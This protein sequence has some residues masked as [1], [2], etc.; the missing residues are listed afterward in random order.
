MNKTLKVACVGEALIEMIAQ[1]IP[2]NAR[3]NVAGDTL[4][5]AI[6]LRRALPKPNSVHYVTGLGTDQMSDQM[7]EFMQSEGLETSGITRIADRLP[8]LYSISNDASGE[9]S[10][11][12]WREN[13]A[14]R[15]LFQES[16]VCDFSALE[17]YDLIYMS[18]ISLAILP[19]SVRVSLLDWMGEY[20]ENGGQFAFDS[21]Y[22]PKL[23]ESQTRARETVAR[24]W[25]LCDIALP[26]LDDEI[27]LF[28]G[29]EA[30]V[31]RRFS[32]I[33]GCIGSLK[34]GERGPIA[35]NAHQDGG[36]TFPKASLVVDTT[37]AGD[38][39]SG[40]FIGSYLQHGSVSK[41]MSLGHHYA[42]V[43]IGHRGAI[44]PNHTKELI[45]DAMA[46]SSYGGN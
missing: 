11:A 36:Q 33:E 18:G 8:G 21:N 46:A 44:V 15:S 7:I 28:G 3:L 29:T 4:N 9:R 5:T 30:A 39:F 23:W 14:A 35:I 31:L 1:A 42:S 24:A 22:R 17:E 34:R 20:R 13:S 32:K 25:S 10:F 41:A 40:A 19:P 37:A 45:F 27:A 2:G 12:Y 43:V 16:G 26:S 38:S 6:Y